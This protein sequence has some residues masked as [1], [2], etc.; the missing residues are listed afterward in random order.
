MKRIITLLILLIA[1]QIGFAQ[2]HEKRDKI[3]A[4]KTAHITSELNLSSKEAERFWPIYNASQ[5]KEHSYRKKMH[6]LRNKVNSE[7]TE[8]EAKKLLLEFTTLSN[9][10]YVTRKQ[11]IDDLN[12]VLPAKKLILLQK[13]EEEFKRKLF[14]QFKEKRRPNGPPRGG[15]H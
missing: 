15:R 7:L 8:A 10:I 14:R 5:E 11:L 4:L 3:K 6:E 1:I 12:N 2:K 9:S 13:A